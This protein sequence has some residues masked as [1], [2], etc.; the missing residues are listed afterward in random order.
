MLRVVSNYSVKYDR[1]TSTVSVYAVQ[2][3]SARVVVSPVLCSAREHTTPIRVLR[4]RRVA[5]TRT[6]WYPVLVMRRVK[7]LQLN[8]TLQ[9]MR[10]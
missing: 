4:F 10:R 5:Q 7:N 6:G 3:E 2:N 8:L 9:Q 1:M